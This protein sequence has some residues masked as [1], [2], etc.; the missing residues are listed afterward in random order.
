MPRIKSKSKLTTHWN[1]I[2]N[3]LAKEFSSFAGISY[4]EYNKTKSSGTAHTFQ[5][6]ICS[7][8]YDALNWNLIPGRALNLL[9]T[10]KFLDN[11]NLKKKYV[12]WI[13]SQPVAKFTGYPF[14]LAKKL[15]ESI[16]GY[17]SYGYGRNREVPIEIKHTLDCQFKGLVEK[18]E[19]DGKI[20]ENVL[21][22]LDTSGSMGRGVSGINGVTCE[23]IAS[24]LA[25]FFANL[26]KGAFH[27][28]IMM[29]DNTSYAYDLPSESFC[30]NIMTLP[31]VPCG[32]TNFQSL[33]DEL[34]KI[35]RQNPEI[36][37]EDYPTTILVVSDMQFNQT[38]WRSRKE[39][40]TNHEV[41]VKKLRA[42]FPNEWVDNLKFIWW[43]CASARKTFE[44]TALTSGSY[45]FSGFDGNIISLLLGEST[46]VDEKTGKVRNLTAEELVVKALSQEILSYVKL[47]D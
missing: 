7:R 10:S 17:I 41:G 2:T 23:D 3:D 40:D 4:K 32:G 1:T 36:P 27:N 43:D 6:L 31:S 25:V 34:I 26:N 30:E 16:G 29:F 24:S 15:R 14:E 9:V 45:F 33:I 39:E 13:M 42:A 21:V 8:N 11:H 28:K 5:K 35:R 37:L 18:A 47:E 19:A 12:E 38:N 20:T 44:T 22:G 46:V